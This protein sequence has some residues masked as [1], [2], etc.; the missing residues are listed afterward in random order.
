[1]LPTLI[2]LFFDQFL[3]VLL[4]AMASFAQMWMTLTYE[5]EE[6]EMMY[7]GYMKAYTMM[8][9][10]EVLGC[11]ISCDLSSDFAHV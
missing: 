4:A 2:N 6:K 9:M 8:V 10:T 3:L 7:E 11:N 5:T 1:M